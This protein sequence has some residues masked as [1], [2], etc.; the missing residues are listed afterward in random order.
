MRVLIDMTSL[1]DEAGGIVTY[2]A[3]LLRGWRSAAPDDELVVLAGPRLPTLVGAESSDSTTWLRTRYGGT[4]GRLA[5]G[6]T[7]TPRLARRTAVDVILSITPVVPLVSEIP[8]VAVVHDLRHVRA[9]GEFGLF[10]RA[11]RDLMYHAGCHRA[12]RLAVDTQ[13]TLTD[14]R[15]WCPTGA[16]RA[17]VVHLGADHVDDWIGARGTHGLAFAQFSNKQP[18]VAIRTWASI[19]DRHPEFE[20]VLH[21][22][23]A[24]T[25]TGRSLR[26]L[27]SDLGV[28]DLVRVEPRLPDPEFQQLFRGA[29][30]VL[31]PSTIEGFGMPVVEAMRLGVPV[32]ASMD[33]A[34]REVGGDAILYA[35]PAVPGAFANACERILLGGEAEAMAAR[36]RERSER[37]SWRVTAEQTRALLHEA[38]TDR[39]G[40]SMRSGG[41]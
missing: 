26:S 36:G 23:G 7:S 41:D 12:A 32:V 19:K 39:S 4:I 3:G 11:Y 8:S 6:Q 20:R 22:V 27:A 2:A 25:D 17:R 34:L 30:I 1:V 5:S 16:A 24:A 40:S 37:F 35:D 13:A 15:R 38:T 29:A 18:G 28:A 31:L 14:L 33:A 9:P 10:Q 21:I